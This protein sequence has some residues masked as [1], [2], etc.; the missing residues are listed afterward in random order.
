VTGPLSLL[1]RERNRPRR[2]TA[3]ACAVLALVTPTVANAG[4]LKPDPSAGPASA[5]LQ[6]DAFHDAATAPT[7][8]TPAPARMPAAAVLPVHSAET[9]PAPVHSPRTKPVIP[10][11]APAVTRRQ[12]APVV[13]T[14]PVTPVAR[15]TVALPRV[16]EGHAET[17]V[18]RVAVK[19]HA[20]PRLSLPATVSGSLTLQV[21]TA[22][23][24]RDLVP[25]ALA[26]LALVATSGCL[27]AVAA[28]S[29]HEELE[30]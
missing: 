8:P 21:P 10:Q 15:R 14:A 23:V 5:R 4:S 1:R 7:A 26:L 30:V 29:R 11:L 19:H 6:P 2:R 17:R 20:A 22:A 25:A 12:V 18:V 13:V 24:R 9:L 16:V 3:F 27:L 28:R